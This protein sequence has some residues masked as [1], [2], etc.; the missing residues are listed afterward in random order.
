MLK[1][2]GDKKK[3]ATMSKSYI[4]YFTSGGHKDWVPEECISYPIY[5]AVQRWFLDLTL[6]DAFF[7]YTFLQTHFTLTNL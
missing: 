2:T 5:T 4:R 6:Y 3:Q 7:Q 1:A